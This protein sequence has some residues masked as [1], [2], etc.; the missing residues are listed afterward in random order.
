M[1]L[2]DWV[3]KIVSRR[4]P[5]RDVSRLETQDAA[6][7][8]LETVDVSGGPLK[9]N[10]LRRAWRDPR[11]LPKKKPVIV[12]PFKRPVKKKYMTADEAGRLFSASL[13]TKNRKLRDLAPDEEQ[14]A[15]YGL[16]VWKSEEDLAEALGV[17]VKRLRYF[18]IH[19]E[20]EK[21]PH[22]VAFTA[23]KRSGGRRM[24][25][26]PKRELKGLQRRL[27]KLLVQRLPVSDRAHGFRRGRSIRTGA[28]PHVGKAVVLHLDIKD[29]FPTVHFGRVRGLLISLGYS[30]PVA[31]TLSLLM[32]EAQ[33]Q[34]VMIH[35]TLYHV[36][37][38]RRY[39][40]QGAPT[41]PGICNALFLKADRRLAG[42]AGSLGFDYTRYADDLTFSGDD[43]GV[44][45]KLKTV[46]QKIIREEGFEVNPGKTRIMRQGRGQRVT[47]VTVNQTLGL[48]RKERRKIRAMVHRL[49]LQAAQGESDPAEVRRLRGKLAYLAMLNPDQAEALRPDFF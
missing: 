34:P 20:K 6:D 25:M 31:A 9:E 3:I 36:P 41:S 30:Y 39:C 7:E 43:P 38:G 18:S 15:R 11:L 5:Q 12:D 10:H 23:P 22:Y 8:V 45:H 24:I 35:R 44:V 14:L 17:S 46:A 32:T 33:R 49:S 2:F 28:E 16:P 4:P 29:F 47:G 42:L 26:A 1:G 40:V 27:N 21:A 48:G 19:R 13:R 37:V